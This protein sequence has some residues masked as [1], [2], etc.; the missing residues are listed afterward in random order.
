MGISSISP[1]GPISS[2]SGSGITNSTTASLE[3]QIVA[4]Q[5]KIQAEQ[6]TKVDDAK[7]K[8]TKLAQY[9]QQLQVLNDQLLKAKS[10]TK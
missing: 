7:T 3:S 2:V 8:A 9:N 1:K 4:L 10:S 6:Q 5:K